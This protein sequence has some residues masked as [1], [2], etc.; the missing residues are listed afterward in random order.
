MPNRPLELERFAEET[1]AYDA[2]AAV[3]ILKKLRDECGKVLCEG[4]AEG[5]ES[6]QFLHPLEVVATE[7]ATAGQDTTRRAQAPPRSSSAPRAG[8]HYEQ[9]MLDMRTRIQSV[10]GKTAT[11]YWK[12][13]LDKDF[14][15]MSAGERAGMAAKWPTSAAFSLADAH[16]ADELEETSPSRG[17]E[18]SK[19]ATPTAPGKGPSPDAG[20]MRA[21]P[22][23]DA[24]ADSPASDQHTAS[25]RVVFKALYDACRESLLKAPYHFAAAIEARGQLLQFRSQ[26]IPRDIQEHINTLRYD[27]D[28]AE[29][30]KAAADALHNQAAS[31]SDGGYAYQEALNAVEWRANNEPN[32]ETRAACL[33]AKEQLC[34]VCESK[35]QERDKGGGAAPGTPPP[36]SS[37]EAGGGPASASGDAREAHAAAPAGQPES[38]KPLEAPRELN[39]CDE[40][41]AAANAL[42]EFLYH[43]DKAKAHLWPVLVMTEFMLAKVRAW[44]QCWE[45]QSTDSNPLYDMA[46]VKAQLN[47]REPSDHSDCGRG[48]LSPIC[49]YDNNSLRAYP[50]AGADSDDSM[51]N[52]AENNA[53]QDLMGLL[54]NRRGTEEKERAETARKLQGMGAAAAEAAGMLKELGKARTGWRESGTDPEEELRAACRLAHEGIEKAEREASRAVEDVCGLGDTLLDLSKSDATRVQAAQALGKAQQSPETGRIALSFLRDIV[55]RSGIHGET[56]WRDHCAARGEDEK[57]ET[58]WSACCESFGQ[59]HGGPEPKRDYYELCLHEEPRNAYGFARFVSYAGLAPDILFVRDP[60]RATGGLLGRK[61]GKQGEPQESA[62]P[63]RSVEDTHNLGSLEEPACQFREAQHIF[64]GDW[65]HT[66]QFEE[67][68]DHSA[69]D[70]VHPKVRLAFLLNHTYADIKDRAAASKTREWARRKAQ[71]TRWR[72][73]SASLLFSAPGISLAILG[74]PTGVLVLSPGSGVGGAAASPVVEEGLLAHARPGQKEAQEKE[75][76]ALAEA[77]GQESRVDLLSHKSEDLFQK[78]ASHLLSA[79]KSLRRLTSMV[80]N[81]PQARPAGS[82]TGKPDKASAF[83][84]CQEAAEYA[85]AALRFA[86]HY[87]KSVSYMNPLAAFVH[88][89]LEHVKQ[90]DEDWRQHGEAYLGKIEEVVRQDEEWHNQHCGDRPR[91]PTELNAAR[92]VEQTVKIPA[93]KATPFVTKYCYGENVSFL[94]HL[95]WEPRRPK[96]PVAFQHRMAGDEELAVGEE[97]KTWLDNARTGWDVKMSAPKTPGKGDGKPAPAKPAAQPSPRPRN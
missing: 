20:T 79:Q 77:G 91:P 36:E 17:N 30:R 69:F 32:E 70:E 11:H 48:L 38:P 13:F 89:A 53:V 35:S 2:A 12:Q 7:D 64:D 29:N 9:M 87:D 96:H 52:H 59:L 71:D 55:H 39:N 44:K 26:A 33:K 95:N 62:L 94:K 41:T 90:W 40:A 67:N 42:C 49:Y 56:T 19:T 72:E 97:H 82:G 83:N 14:Q 80:H 16:G 6:P 47:S 68:S 22:A 86:H 34:D 84:D 57:T 5:E 45:G 66:F 18:V 85:W 63:D 92:G 75:L 46:R 88:V 15:D 78:M 23:R 8:D 58:V 28:S 43:Y 93:E 50:W 74:G 76:T 25:E 3:E 1:S 31:L 24:L 27:L 65:S 54:R 60:A 81:K 10:S 37:G 4:A 73:A 21:I 61:E 51:G